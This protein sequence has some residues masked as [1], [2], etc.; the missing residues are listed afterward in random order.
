MRQV[1][2]AIQLRKFQKRREEN[3]R[4]SWL[5]R[6]IAQYIA[7]G[8]QIAEGKVNEPLQ[9]A[10]FLAIDDIERALLKEYVASEAEKPKEN[11]NGSFERLLG[12]GGN[13]QAQG[14]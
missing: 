2:S 5:G 7:A 6:N 1:A 3:E 14:Q 9:N 11:S 13:M 8:F 4:T 12:F 10:G